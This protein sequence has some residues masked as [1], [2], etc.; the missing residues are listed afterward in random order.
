[1]IF[2]PRASRLRL[3]LLSLL[4]PLAACTVGGGPTPLQPTG[5]AGGGPRSAL[6]VASFD[7]P[8]S[9][10]LAE[11]Y[12]QA[13]RR[14]GYP[15]EV[16]GGLGPREL[17]EPALARGLI[18]LV[19]EYAGSAL[20]FLTLG[21]ERGSKPGSTHRALGRAL[22]SR[23]LVALEAAPAQDTNAIVVTRAT[24]RRYG[25]RTISDLF[26]AAPRLT[27][28]GPPECPLREL[29]LLGLERRYGLH[30]EAPFWGLDTGGPVTLQALRDGDIDV[31]LLFSTDPNIERYDLTVLSDDRGLQPAEN[32]TPVIRSQALS[33]FGP[34]VRRTVDAVSARLTTDVVRTLN[35][36]LLRS[37]A[38]ADA[39]AASWLAA[40][41]LG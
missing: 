24:S 10:V 37:G 25:L 34:G 7:F 12:G 31:A 1:M 11:I 22:A 19:P 27:F 4:L 29:C 13:L 14:A 15:V 28:G 3:G 40:Q 23:G 5:P 20:Q 8:E 16:L 30:F 41:G 18:D 32:I 6:T 39:V 33:R 17:L 2:H 35:A 9:E 36:R 38:P 21:R 26:G